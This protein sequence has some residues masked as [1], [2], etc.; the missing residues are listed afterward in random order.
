MMT[1]VRG[2][3]LSTSRSFEFPCE[4]FSLNNGLSRLKPF[5]QRP[6]CFVF[7]L[8]AHIRI[9]N[10][11]L[12]F[13]T[14]FNTSDVLNNF[15]KSIAALIII[16]LCGPCKIDEDRF[17]RLWIINL[18]TTRKLYIY[19]RLGFL[20][21]NSVNMKYVVHVNLLLAYCALSLAY[22]AFDLLSA[23]Q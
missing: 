19:L 5:L 16:D 20:T 9:S 7:Y 14:S 22:C 2:H 15:S 11:F 8:H 3:S 13:D 23:Q 6:I 18:S 21:V 1:Q 4:P 12:M 10:N 17:A